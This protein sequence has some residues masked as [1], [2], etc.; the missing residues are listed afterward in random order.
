MSAKKDYERLENALEQAMYAI[1]ACIDECIAQL[2][3]NDLTEEKMGACK[4]NAVALMNHIRDATRV[5]GSLLEQTKEERI[6][7]KLNGLTYFLD[8]MYQCVEPN[9]STSLLSCLKAEDASRG[10]LVLEKL[11]KDAAELSS[12]YEQLVEVLE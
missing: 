4:K 2:N 7:S 5:I 6:T 11:K 3:V 9:T 8:D 10:R 12:L 1:R